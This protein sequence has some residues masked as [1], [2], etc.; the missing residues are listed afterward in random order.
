MEL[1]VSGAA[2][3]IV[4]GATG[5]EGIIQNVY[6]AITTAQGSVP[7]ARDFGIPLDSL[8]QPTPIAQAKL[9]AQIIETVQRH[10]S[11]VTVLSV[12]YTDDHKEGKLIPNVRIRV[13]EGV[14]I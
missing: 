10:E 3:P 12:S 6:T 4:F 5:L 1:T 9:T 8:D 7:M 14:E 13:N 11:R 2:R